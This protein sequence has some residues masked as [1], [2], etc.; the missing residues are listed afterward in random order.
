M[1]F[2]PKDSIAL[3]GNTGPF[4]QYSHARIQRLLAKAKQ[5]PTAPPPQ[6][7]L[8]LEA[9]EVALIEWLLRGQTTLVQA[10]E[11]YNP[12]LVA[13]YLYQLAKVFNRFY[14]LLPV[15]QAPSPG[16]R[17]RRLY[18]AARTAAALRSFG[19]LLGMVMPEQM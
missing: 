10:A 15:L 12:A 13:D 9:A 17:R 7:T 11:N 14:T 3:E 2:D 1:R 18:L 4:I 8:P 16:L 6:G 5:W 19:K